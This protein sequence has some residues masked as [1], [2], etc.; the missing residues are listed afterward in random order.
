MNEMPIF[1]V[2]LYPRALSFHLTAVFNI[3]FLWLF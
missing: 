3:L 1:A 2:T